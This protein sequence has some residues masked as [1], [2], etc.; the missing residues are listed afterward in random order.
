MNPMTGTGYHLHSVWQRQNLSCLVETELL[1]KR[2]DQSL[3]A[4]NSL[5]SI[6]ELFDP[7]PQL[8]PYLPQN[9]Q[10]ITSHRF[11]LKITVYN[12]LNIHVLLRKNTKKFSLSLKV[13]HKKLEINELKRTIYKIIQLNF[14]RQT[15]SIILNIQVL[16]NILRFA[17]TLSILLTFIFQ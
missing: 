10:S 11:L 14:V 16:F 8:Y 7:F 4:Q 9:T 17:K 13:N 2:Q 15:Y 5:P 6:P 12:S 3:T 1:S